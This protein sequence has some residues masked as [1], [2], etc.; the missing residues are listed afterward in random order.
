MCPQNAKEIADGNK[1][2]MQCCIYKER[3]ISEERVL[4]AMG[5]DR[6]NPNP[7]AVINIACDRATDPAAPPQRRDPG[8]ARPHGIA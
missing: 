6:S 5:G 2:S 4:M 1:E 3:A 7:I 8:S